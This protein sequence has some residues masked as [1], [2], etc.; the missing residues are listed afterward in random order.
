MNKDTFVF[1]SLFFE[2]LKPHATSLLDSAINIADA[3]VSASTRAELRATESA[4]V[5]ETSTV[6][7]R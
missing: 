6:A 2:A 1:M 3:A 4:V 7:N 5:V